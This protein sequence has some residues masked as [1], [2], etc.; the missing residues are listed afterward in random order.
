RQ[1]VRD[2]ERSDYQR[3][4]GEHEQEGLQEVQ[5][6]RRAGGVLGGLVLG[7]ADLGAAGQDAIDGVDQLLL[8]GA[9]LRG[10]QDLVELARFVEDALRGTQVEPGQRRAAP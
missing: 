5:E 6:V 2:H 9:R 4:R 1:R 7:T 10:D 3:D 8:A